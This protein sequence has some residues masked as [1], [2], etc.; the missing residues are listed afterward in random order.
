MANEHVKALYFTSALQ[1]IIFWTG[2]L[3]TKKILGIESFAYFKMLAIYIET[4]I[5]IIIV[6]KYLETNVIKLIKQIFQPAILPI[7]V[8][9]IL[10]LIVKPYMPY[11]IGKVNLV[12]YFLFIV[13]INLIG[14]F[15]YY[16][17]SKVFK[18]FINN[19]ILNFIQ[20]L[21]PIKLT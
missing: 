14:I 3:L 1:P 13:I 6:V 2:I 20:K 19:L 17:T 18:V 7:F 12:Y 15:T 10:L 9:I 5:Y 8:I 4:I 11:S 21:K 16:F